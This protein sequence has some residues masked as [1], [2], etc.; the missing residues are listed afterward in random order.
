MA[1]TQENPMLAERSRALSGPEVLQEP[2]DFSL[3][4]GGP[5]FQFFRKS[6]LAGDG[7]QLLHRRLLVI[8][9]LAWIPLL[10]LAAVNPSV[11]EAGRLAFFHDVEVHTRF[12]LAL[13]IL[14]AAE[15]IVHSRLRPVVRRFVERGIVLPNDLPRFHNAVNSAVRLR[16]SVAVELGILLFLY[17]LSLWLWNERPSIV[18]STWYGTPGSSWH[19]TAAGFWY[20]FVSIPILR[21]ILFRWY[22]RI[23]IWFRF[24]WQVSRIDLHLI[25]TH[26]DRAAGLAFLGKSAYAFGPILFAQG[27]M[28]A[29]VVAE[30]VLYRGQSLIS[31]KVQIAGFVVFFVLAILGP[32][33]MFTPRLAQAKR[34]GLADYGLLAQ[35]YVENFEQKWVAGD[36]SHSEDL[37]GTS[38]IQSLA[39]LGNGYAMVRDMRPIPFW[40]EDVSRLAAATAAPLVPL[41][42]TIF[43]PE[44]LITRVM[45]I[46][47]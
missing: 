3:V 26:P 16:D 40:L 14:V 11:G 25:P 12:L 39:D 13:P 41:L 18:S 37:L 32:L 44:E 4:L 17:P 45:K 2:I 20:V 47:F 46:V 24:L 35:R 21:F 42:L 38:D 23:F 19:L 34:K 43:S 15:L 36:P 29:G 28:L 5:I 30:R 33:L 31:F 9:F 10:I 27:A 8:T 22:L 1:S 7:L 6:H